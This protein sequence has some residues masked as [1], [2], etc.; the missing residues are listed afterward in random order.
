MS[1]TEEHEQDYKSKR[2]ETLARAREIARQNRL[3]KTA[4]KKEEHKKSMEEA[5]RINMEE[6]DA[7]RRKYFE[8]KDRKESWRFTST[9]LCYGKY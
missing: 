7:E 2:L 5:A 3:A 4:E 1:D 8:E 6:E 9:A